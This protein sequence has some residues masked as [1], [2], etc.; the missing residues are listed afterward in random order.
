MRVHVLVGIVA[1]MTAGPAS[2]QGREGPGAV[3]ERADGNGDGV[4]ARDEFLSARAD[5]FGTRD[6][7]SDGFIDTSD[8]GERA[9]QRPRLS[10][11]MT[12][13]VTQ[14]DA[15]KDGKVSKVE[16]V[17]GG[18]KMFD[19]ADADKN[20]SLDSKEIETAKAALRERASR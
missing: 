8:F 4:I 3:F 19:R 7:N 9:T 16:F 14:F 10:Q 11:A 2:S 6:R 5:Q 18:A 12:A 1:V 15:D 13:M 17:D 20:N